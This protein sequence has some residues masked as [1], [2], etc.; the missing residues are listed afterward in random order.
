MV[1][2]LMGSSRRGSAVEPDGF[3]V[4]VTREQRE[5]KILDGRK[6]EMEAFL[7]EDKVDWEKFQALIGIPGLNPNL[8][9]FSSK[10]T[11]AHRA[12]YD[13]QAQ[14]LRW[15]VRSGQDP[16]AKTAIG[17]SILHMACDGNSMGCIREL[18]QTRADVNAISLSHQT[19]LHVACQ[20][21]SFDAVLV[22]LDESLAG[23]VVDVNALDSRLRS[24]DML[25]QNK[26]IVRAVNKYRV[27]MNT[28]KKEELVERKVL[29]LFKII[30]R[31][32]SGSISHQEW[33]DVQALLARLF[34]SHCA[35]S[36]DEAFEAA[37]ANHD[38][39]VDWEEF[40]ESYMSMI[41]AAKV[42][43]Q[44]LMSNL[45]DVESRLFEGQVKQRGVVTEA[46]KLPPL[47]PVTPR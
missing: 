44:A 11:T 35:D 17:R 16:D 42:S 7:E 23:Q 40:K 15:C 24:P 43:Q 39:R 38:G 12:A 33:V 14:V 4:P 27:A 28:K 19:P 45:S 29:R 34:D 10:V 22:M 21:G 6:R 31:D 47:R 46:V 8:E 20:A 41:G 37:D 32:G 1:L 9:N 26:K 25:T 3:F 5:K 13:N 30:D 18:L 36:I 2:P